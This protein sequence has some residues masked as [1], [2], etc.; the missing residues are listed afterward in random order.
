MKQSP[1]FDWIVIDGERYQSDDIIACYMEDGL[2]R[3]ITTTGMLTYGGTLA[4][5]KAKLYGHGFTE[6]GKHGLVNPKHVIGFA[7]GEVGKDLVLTGGHRIH[8]SRR[9]EFLFK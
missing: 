9:S 1:T 6:V 3:M 8:V 5:M 2:P 4:D 7:P